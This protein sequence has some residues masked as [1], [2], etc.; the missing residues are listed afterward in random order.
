[1]DVLSLIKPQELAEFT[2]SYSY[3]R[4]YMGQKLFT[5]VK[6]ENPKISY[7]QLVEGGE[8]P[9]MAQVHAL[10]TEARIGER[11]N[12]QKVELE[13]LLIK[14]KLPVSERVAYF[15][16]N[17]G[18]QDGVVR[19]IFN[20]AANL[21][22]RVI[23]RTEVANMEL[24]STGKITVEENNAKYTVDY[25]FKSDNK[26]TFSGWEK[27]AHGI[28]ADLNS[29]QKKAQAKGFK[30]VRAITSSTVIGYMLANTEIK[31]FWKD[32]TAPLTQT[33]LL[34]WINDYY[35]IE[36]VVNDDVYKVNV[37]DATTKRFFD[38]KAIC[39]LSTK[40]SLGRGFFGVTPEELQLRDKVGHDIKE[41]SLCTL[42]MWAQDD[43]AITWTK[44]TGMYLPAPIAI[45]KMFIAN[46]TAEA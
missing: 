36:F 4:N 3:N 20:D 16:R 10:D 25:G 11:P 33:S 6:T 46:L 37:N 26:L 29:V 31:S 19:Y 27:P 38:E 17:G 5:P 40:G 44:A 39:F 43:P 9:V 2:E 35:G 12:F 41:S 23:T 32:K 7:E 1:M 21:L 34:A 24:L 13:K 15:L 45:N 22:S 28:L 14:E 42:T 18:N 30:I 8:L